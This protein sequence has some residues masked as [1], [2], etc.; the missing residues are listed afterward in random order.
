MVLCGHDHKG[1]YH[2]ARGGVHHLTLCSPLNKGR[3]GKAYGLVEVHHDRIELR[4][5][6]LRDLLP[7]HAA[8][9]ADL[10]DGA[11][12]GRRWWRPRG[13]RSRWGE[14]QSRLPAVEDGRGGEDLMRFPL[15]GW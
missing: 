10:D 8:D 11:D 13:W 6:A 1:G 15:H 7:V 3:D 9:D 4:G 12:R 2:R 5:P 14:R